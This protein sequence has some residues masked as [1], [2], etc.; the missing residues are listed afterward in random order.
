MQSKYV[1][2]V[3]GAGYIGSHTA[4]ALAA[5]GF[6]PVTYDNLS[7]GHRWAVQWGPFV[8]G[9]IRDRSKLVETIKRYNI[10]AVVHFAAF[11]Y[12][13][14]S[15]VRPEVYFDNNVAGSLNLLDAML[16]SGV[17]HIIFSSSCATYGTPDR[18]PIT[19]NTPQS[20]VNP[21]GET[22]LIIERALRWYA[23]AHPITYAALRYFNS[24]GADSEG[25]I[26]ED[27]SPETHLIPLV[28]EAAL[29]GKPIKVYGDDY[30]TSDGTCV[31]DYIH[32]SDLADAH[33]RALQ[34]LLQGGKSAAMNLGTGNGYSV[35]EVIDAVRQVT[36]RE[37]PHSIAARRPGDPAVLVASPQLAE[38]LLGWRPKESELSHIVRSAWNWHSNRRKVV[39]APSEERMLI[40]VVIATKNRE[41]QLS[42]VSLPSLARQQGAPSF[43]V[44]V[45][46]ASD[47]DKSQRLVAEFAAQNPAV[48]VRYFKAPRIG[49]A[50]Q[51]NDAV[52]EAKG[53]VV[54][55]IDDDSEISPDGIQ[56][57]ADMF[58]ADDRIAGGC[59]PLDYNFPDG[60]K[61]AILKVSGD[62]PVAWLVKGY[63]KVFEPSK[64]ASGYFPP[65]PPTGSGSIS[66]LF[67]CDM[68]F[69]KEIFSTHRFE[70]RLQRFSNYVIC[71]DLIFSRVLLQEGR[72][73][74][75]AGSGYVIHKA[76]SGG[77]F[78]F[79][80][81]TGRVEGY[82]AGLVWLVSAFP[83][84]R[85]TIFPF[86]WARTGV[87][88][89]ALLP[90]LRRPW[91]LNT[92]GRIAGYLS[93]LWLFFWEE[94]FGFGK[95]N[96]R[97]S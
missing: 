3:G 15:M 7:Y 33:V 10:A 80:F 43:E 88:C 38:Q 94:F 95:P 53:D 30:P 56:A 81:D 19:E 44:I 78:K 91:Q 75:V 77:R 37:V 46:D 83:W 51:R 55:F 31:R 96:P 11:G 92:W 87:F 41:D 6:I 14:E 34:Y 49:L 4:K 47:N 59:L 27:H 68:A 54:F 86:F 45:W 18:L 70:E 9:D 35:R 1:L 58:A 40:S 67:G 20:P 26:G 65:I 52:K 5:H 64:K 97:L 17:R 71:D 50:R 60:T 29:G 63:Y 32:V 85:W 62:G 12:V 66:H 73:L 76:A 22:K 72:Q 90:C 74:Q 23:G 82:N 84:S 39:P 48:D 25:T 13:G 42:S 69:R 57:L 61:P 89:A 16:E 8:E 24:A 79:G 93:G 2:V 36:G 28:F 21:Y